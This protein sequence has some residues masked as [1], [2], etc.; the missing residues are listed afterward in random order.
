MAEVRFSPFPTPPFNSLTA[1][2]GYRA[3]LEILFLRER[4]F[5]SGQRRLFLFTLAEFSAPTSF[6]FLPVQDAGGNTAFAELPLY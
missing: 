5:E 4:Q 3:R 1:P 6:V 2:S